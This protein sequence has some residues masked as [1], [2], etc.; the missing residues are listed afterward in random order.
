MRQEFA[1]TYPTPSELFTIADVGGWPEVMEKFFDKDTG[2][3]A[4]IN[5]KLGVPLE[6]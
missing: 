2:I 4:E 5:K 3:V 1:D 6:G